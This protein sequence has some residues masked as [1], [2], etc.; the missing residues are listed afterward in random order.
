MWLLSHPIWMLMH[1]DADLLGPPVEL[2]EVTVNHRGPV[3]YK[4]ILSPEIFRWRTL[5]QSSQ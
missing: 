5:R 3:S 2:D 4:K 1:V